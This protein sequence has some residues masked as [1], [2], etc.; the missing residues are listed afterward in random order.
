MKDLKRLVA[1]GVTAVCVGGFAAHAAQPALNVKL[2]LW[3]TQVNPQISGDLAT[4]IP[5]E[6]LQKMTPEQRAK[7]QQAMQAMQATMAQP[8]VG[9]DC[10]T[11]EKLAKGFNFGTEES[12]QCKTTIVTNSGS[13]FESHQD[14]TENGA[15]RSTSIHIIAKSTDHISGVIHSDSTKGA[16]GMVFNATMEGK[17]LG[18]DCG[19]IKD[20]QLEKPPGR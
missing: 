2:G 19:T 10:M 6:Q 20:Y 17:W 18:P 4:S 9:K 15:T 1:A 11:A 3:E 5:D 16:K 8:H 12:P 7:M 14:C 13:E